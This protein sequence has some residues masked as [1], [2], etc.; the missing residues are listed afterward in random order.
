MKGFIGEFAKLKKATMSCV[1]SVCPSARC[2]AP[3]GGILLISEGFPNVFRE[4]Q[5]FILTSFALKCEHNRHTASYMFRP[6]LSVVISEFL[7]Q[8]KFCPSNWPV[9]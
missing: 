7:Y 1:M 3:A 5:F 2:S 9:M 6:F 8:L 4:V